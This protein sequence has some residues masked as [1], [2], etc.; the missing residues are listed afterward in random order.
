MSN[1]WLVSISVWVLRHLS[2]ADETW[3]FWRLSL[4]TIIICIKK[5]MPVDEGSVEESVGR[6][7]ELPLRNTDWLYCRGTWITNIL[8]VFALKLLYSSFPGIT[9]E[10]SWT[11]TNLTYNIVRFAIRKLRLTNRLDDVFF[12]S[13]AARNAFWWSEPGW[14]VC[15]HVV[16]A[17]RQWN[18]S[19]P[20]SQVFGYFS[21]CIVSWKI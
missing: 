7:D 12:L 19:H 21:R 2:K 8:I 11:L 13:L 17:N 14:I 10:T 15:A 18:C 16:G 5:L 1:G 6:R 3:T 20:D 4:K 9:P